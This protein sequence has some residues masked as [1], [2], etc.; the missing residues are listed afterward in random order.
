MINRILIILALL[1]GLLPAQAQFQSVTTTANGTLHSPTN[2]WAQN[3]LAIANALA[4]NPSVKVV[5]RATQGEN[6]QGGVWLA[7][8]ITSVLMT[9]SDHSGTIINAGPGNLDLIDEDTI[10][11][12]TLF[13][14]E[15]INYD[16]SELNIL[17]ITSSFTPAPLTAANGIL[18][19]TA[20]G[21]TTAR[22]ITGT[23]GQI[24]VTNGNGTSGN[25]TLSLPTTITGNRTL[26]DNLTVQG[27]T[28]LGDASGDT[29]T[30]L[31]QTIT[32]SNANGTATNSIA[33]V[34]TLDGRYR[35]ITLRPTVNVEH[36]S[37]TGWTVG[38][39][40]ITLPVGT[41]TFVGQA[42]GFT[43]STTDGVDAGFRIVSGT[44]SF[45]RL[46]QRFNTTGNLTEINF[47]A[48]FNTIISSNTT[49]SGS[50]LFFA[51]AGDANAAGVS[52]LITAS[53]HI[54]I[55]S[56]TVIAFASNKRGSSSD[57]ANPATARATGSFITF[58]PTNSSP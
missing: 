12:A 50:S 44:G 13:P 7:S 25:P 14:G 51:T 45:R 34:G 42:M 53:G 26:Q 57:T 35:G 4:E 17:T 24:D 11:V 10:T 37:G 19:R 30:I 15:V 18:A 29:L 16:F 46:I 43:T 55:T 9:P 20:A 36:L 6:I 27:N 49:F 48:A 31:P 3:S 32:A 28:T 54:N 2:L 47:T 21:T 33:N 38:N 22:T 39:E 5:R 56:T 8:G 1:A 40:T 52:N 23:A 41:Y 58:I